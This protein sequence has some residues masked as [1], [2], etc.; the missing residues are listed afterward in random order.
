MFLTDING[1]INPHFYTRRDLRNHNFKQNQR[2]ELKV[3][4]CK[5]VKAKVHRK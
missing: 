2:K 5:K 4:H 3:S 1:K